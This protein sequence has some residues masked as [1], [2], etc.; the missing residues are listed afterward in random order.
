MVYLT[1]FFFR[2][3]VLC[4]VGCLIAEFEKKVEWSGRAIP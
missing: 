3:H 2:R 1:T 4:S